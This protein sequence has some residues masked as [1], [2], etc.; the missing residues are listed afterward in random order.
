MEYPDRPTL[1]ELIDQSEGD[2]LAQLPDMEE[3]PPESVEKG[4][5]AATAGL[6]HEEHNHLDWIRR[7]MF[8]D[9]ADKENLEHHASLKGVF[10]KDAGVAVGPIGATGVE[11]SP[12]AAGTEYI[13]SDG[14][15]YVTTQEAVITDGAALLTVQAS[16]PGKSGNT[17]AELTLNLVSPV[18]GI[19][20]AALVA[21]PGILGGADTEL[22]EDLLSRYLQAIRE[23]PDGGAPHD[24]E[25]WAREADPAVTRAFV[26][27]CYPHPAATTVIIVDDN[28][29]PIVPSAETIARVL[30]YIKDPG[31]A[32]ETDTVIV[33]G[34]I[35][36][37]VNFLIYSP[38]SAE[39]REAILQE[40]KD[41]FK[42]FPKPK[43]KMPLS[44]CRTAIGKAKGLTDYN[45]ILPAADIEASGYAH[46]LTLGTVA[47]SE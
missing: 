6:S 12:I 7:Q 33:R 31:R 22:D 13:R 10:R 24:Y 25:R 32:P 46:M 43:M 5:A 8:A 11:G 40:L 26:H 41:L 34:P 45:I 1:P 20:T 30:A 19:D 36:Q 9:T 38:D 28:S 37:P 15:V 17:V 39:V 44:R 23:E 4:L 18:P 16:T 47:W 21:A 14:A 29:S 42:R 35:P 2:I 27:S 3:I